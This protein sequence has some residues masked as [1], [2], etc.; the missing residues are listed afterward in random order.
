MKLIKNSINGLLVSVLAFP[1]VGIGSL[2]VVCGLKMVSLDSQTSKIQNKIEQ[3]KL[4]VSQSLRVNAN[5]D[6]LTGSGTSFSFTLNNPQ[7]SPNSIALQVVNKLNSIGVPAPKTINSPSYIGG[8][9]GDI[10]GGETPINQIT[11]TYDVE[12]NFDT[13]RFTYQ[14]PEKI[15]CVVD[16]NRNA[17]LCNGVEMDVLLKQLLDTAQVTSVDVQGSVRKSWL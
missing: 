11:V 14:L 6:C 15:P 16:M 7:G 1:V 3:T 17:V 9:D 13:Y 8:H 4:P 5:G 10:S 2:W 12:N